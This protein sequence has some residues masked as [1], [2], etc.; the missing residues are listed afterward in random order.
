[1]RSGVQ[2]GV[3]GSG[4]WRMYL[5]ISNTGK[6]MGIDG[7]VACNTRETDCRSKIQPLE[8]QR[9]EGNVTRDTRCTLQHTVSLNSRRGFP[10][11][12]SLHSV[13]VGRDPCWQNRS[14]THLFRAWLRGR[15][16]HA[17]P[18]RHVALVLVRSRFEVSLR[19]LY[20]EIASWSGRTCAAPFDDVGSTPD[21]PHLNKTVSQ[22]ERERKH[23]PHHPPFCYD[24]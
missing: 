13:T 16:G 19:H 9:M 4:P 24:P 17:D 2:V 20:A 12:T 6:T 3:F 5:Y 10:S 23:L 11:H 15:F 14:S 8:V 18:A 22:L 7:F 1:M 21:V